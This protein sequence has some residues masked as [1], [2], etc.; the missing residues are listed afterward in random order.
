M[1]R[2]SIGDRYG[3][4]SKEQEL[5]DEGYKKPS[6]KIA[7]AMS[8]AVL[9]P[10]KE[11]AIQKQVMVKSTAANTQP[12][13]RQQIAKEMTKEQEPEPEQTPKQEQPKQEQP[14][15]ETPEEE[16]ETLT[17]GFQDALLYFGPRLGAMILGGSEAAEITDQ[18]LQGF[19]AHQAGLQNRRLKER[20]MKLRE[21]RGQEDDPRLAYRKER[22]RIQ[23]QRFRAQQD[24]TIEKERQE[25]QASIDD[26]NAQIE[27]LNRAES[28]LSDPNVVG[29]V[30]G[31]VGKYADKFGIAGERGQRRQAAR[32]FLQEIRV[33]EGL[34]KSI[35]LKG[36]ISDKEFATLFSGVPD[37][38]DDDPVWKTW[39]AERKAILNKALGKA[40]GGRSPQS[41]KAGQTVRS[42]T[43]GKM[44]KIM[45]DGSKQEIK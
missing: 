40:T 26:I 21:Q 16:R 20:D 34:K 28:Y 17:Q 22:D 38:S 8:E 4:K 15:K 3:K 11:E 19:E 10:E 27:R 29:P 33:D 1:A 39:F 25:K 31:T 24:A 41:F 18:T 37:L 7:K 13:A 2:I 14:R 5:K 6:K 35:I 43:T 36:A 42:K 23:D 32:K 45:P 44:F 12:T 9:A 30:G